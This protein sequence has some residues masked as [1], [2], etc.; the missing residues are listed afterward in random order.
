M[1][2]KTFTMNG[3]AKQ[4]GIIPIAIFD[5]FDAVEKFPDRIFLFRVTYLEVYKEQVKDLLNPDPTSNAN[6]KIQFDDT[7]KTAVV[8]G[9]KEQVVM[10]AVQVMSLLQSGEMYRH[11]GATGEMLL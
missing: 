1:T 9:V 8:R 2:G 7:T 10:N 5:A 6:I 11:V 4:P 3:T